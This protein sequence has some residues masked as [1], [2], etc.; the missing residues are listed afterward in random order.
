MKNVNVLL[1]VFVAA[2]FGIIVGGIVIYTFDDV[3]V[4]EVEAVEFGI[5]A[6]SIDE[7]I[8]EINLMR[9]NGDVG[10]KWNLFSDGLSGWNKDSKR[11]R[12]KIRGM[13]PELVELARIHDPKVYDYLVVLQ[14]KLK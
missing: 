8:T 6:M 12:L 13:L 9:L 3:A 2:V 7:L 5:D 11:N 4:G 1:T 14:R 10:S